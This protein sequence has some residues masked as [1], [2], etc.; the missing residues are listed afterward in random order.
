MVKKTRTPKVLKIIVFDMDETIGA[1]PALSGVLYNVQPFLQN[2]SLFK[3]YLDTNPQYIRPYMM[4]I[5][6]QVAAAKQLHD[7]TI[8]L[9]TNNSNSVWIAMILYYI[10]TALQ[11]SDPLF[12]HVLDASQHK[13]YDKNVADLL[14]RSNIIHKQKDIRIFFV[15]DQ[16]HPGMVSSE[17]VYFHITPYKDPNSNDVQASQ[18][19]YKE[20][21]KFINS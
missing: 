6:R 18:L 15:D 8:V 12:D 3:H 21:R 4:D 1:F 5:L 10:N 2:Y 16:Y 9:Y 7:L 19:L 17:V 20:L 11:L 14:H 13:M